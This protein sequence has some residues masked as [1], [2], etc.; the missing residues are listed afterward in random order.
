MSRSPTQATNVSFSISSIFPQI[1]RSRAIPRSPI[2]L[3]S[4]FLKK[5]D[6]ALNPTIEVG[7]VKLFV[8]SVQVIVRQTE[9]H[10]HAWD[11]QHVLEIGHDGNR[12]AGADEDRVFFEDFMQRL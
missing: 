12:S 8:G 6:D 9:A 5:P 7:D 2:P 1:T 3:L 10:H 4:Q 11:F